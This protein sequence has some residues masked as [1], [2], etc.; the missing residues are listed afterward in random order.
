[1]HANIPK[2][3]RGFSLLEVL[4]AV[5]IMSVG[6][7]AL[8]ALQVN[9]MRSSTEAKTQSIAINVARDKLE[10]LIAYKT[11]EDTSC[12]GTTDS[13]RCID[14][15]SDNP[16]WGG[17]TFTRTWTVNRCTVA[18]GTVTCGAANTAA[19]AGSTPRNE[20]KVITVLTSWPDA[21]GTT[22]TVS[23]KNSVS[24]FQPSDIALLQK[25]SSKLTPRF[26]RERIYDPSAE[27]GVIPIA[28]GG[29]TESA[30]TNPKPELIVGQAVVETRFD[31]LTYSGLSGGS[32]DAQSRVETAMVGCTCD[33]GAAPADQNPATNTARSMRPTYWN[34]FRYTA[35]DSAT[36]VPKAGAANVTQS[37]KCSTCCA[38]HFDPNTLTAGQPKFSP[39]VATHN[40]YNSNANGAPAVISGQYKEACRM[41]R[42]DGIFRV[43][44]DVQNDYFGLLATKDMTVAG[45]RADFPL[46]DPT[47][48]VWYQQFVVDYL[49][50]RYTNS[51]TKYNLKNGD[52]G[53]INPASYEVK[54]SAPTRDLNAP[55]TIVFTNNDDKWLHSRG[56][57]IDYLEQDAL[58]AIAVAKNDSACTASATALSTC[59]L[60][61]LPFTSINLTE[62]ADWASADSN[63][64][65]V[66][67]QNYSQSANVVNP[68]NGEVTQGPSP[69]NNTTV[70][71]SS[72]SK[73]S[74]SGLLDL[75]FDSI[76]FADSST[77]T[78]S[79]DFNINGSVQA[80]PNGGQFYVFLT[81]PAGY[82]AQTPAVSYITGT[83]LSKSCGTPRPN[84]VLLNSTCAV[85]NGTSSPAA[86]LGVAN[87]MAITIGNY[88]Y[89]KDIVALSTSNQISCTGNMQNGTQYS[90]Y[91]PSGTEYHRNECHRLAVAVNTG[92]RNTTLNADSTG[93]TIL[94]GANTGAEVTKATFG[95]IN[96]DPI[97]A[98]TTFVDKIDV[99]FTEASSTLQPMTC[100]FTCTQYNN[101]GT[102]K[103][104]KTSFVVA[105]TNCP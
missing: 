33:F 38:D 59:I 42:V 69:G 32:A 31:V 5:V 82:P 37:S 86:G 11:L 44:P 99:T 10:D 79:Q 70:G 61:L 16:V 34:G 58:D 57:Y 56:L 93:V 49:D 2:R 50:A 60:K 46:P 88:N 90:Q 94:S 65:L 40:H 53:A 55:S 73:K 54:V 78:D 1:M 39:Y 27:A 101:D 75:A 4:V 25:K 9:I 63:Q 105:S 102:C 71:I 83:Q 81:M 67:T 21:T 72:I 19:Y 24:A 103:S 15:S 29:G 47:A 26:A 48:T 45:D 43:A 95:L 23:V 76:S 68:V 64:L 98:D 20:F 22:Q 30:A 13:Y 85:N 96:A 100:T 77:Y 6:L 51:T 28:V 62:I 52:V 104:N 18:A 12:P 35:P 66:T 8:A 92:A 84:N 41:I 17:I 91:L 3:Q 74:N 7:L 14:G 36:Y 80:S 87:T 97:T 89:F